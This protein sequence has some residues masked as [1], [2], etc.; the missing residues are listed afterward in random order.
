MLADG[1]V[2]LPGA[3]NMPAYE[4]HEHISNQ[5]SEKNPHEPNLHEQSH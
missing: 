1:S 5:Q 4:R 3:A 2:A